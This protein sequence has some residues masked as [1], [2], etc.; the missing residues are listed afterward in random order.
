MSADRALF[1]PRCGS[2]PQTPRFLWSDLWRDSVKP[3]ARFAHSSTRL[4]P[5]PGRAESMSDSLYLN[6]VHSFH[7]LYYY[8]DLFLFIEE[9]SALGGR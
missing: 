8:E 1:T 9:R 3:G 5:Q 4:H 7:R 6:E 2:L